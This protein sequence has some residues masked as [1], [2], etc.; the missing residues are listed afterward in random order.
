MITST[1][2]LNPKFAK[3][4]KR[5]LWLAKLQSI[6]TGKRA[7]EY[8]QNRN[9]RTVIRLDVYKDGSMAAYASGMGSKDYSAII[10]KALEKN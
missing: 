6:K 7:T 10:T 5:A 9:G 1:S 4:I 3:R 2:L 8:V